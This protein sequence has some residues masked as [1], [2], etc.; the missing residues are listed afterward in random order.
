MTT[1]KLVEALY[2][3]YR[4]AY[5]VSTPSADFDQLLNDAE[6]DEHGRKVIPYM[7]YE[8]EEAVMTKILDDVIKEYNI[9]HIDEKAMR[10]SF[11]LGCGPKTKIR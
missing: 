9:K 2:E 7:E 3:A 5:K 1:K 6:I 10:F 4:R 11:W 8:C